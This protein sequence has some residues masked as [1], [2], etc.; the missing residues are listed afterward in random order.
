VGLPLRTGPGRTF[1]LSFLPPIVA[2]AV[3]TP[4]LY[5]G[6]ATDA[7]PGAWLLLYGVGVVTAGT[8]SIR[9]VPIMGLSFMLVGAAAL[10]TSPAFADLYMAV[11]FGALHLVFGFIIARRYGG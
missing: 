8:F 11:G 10:F 2:G 5:L 4:A 9:V 7:I 6:A 3:L 1:V